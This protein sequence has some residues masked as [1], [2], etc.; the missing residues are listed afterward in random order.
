MTL[1]LPVIGFFKDLAAKRPAK[2]LFLRETLNLGE[3]RFLAI[4]ECDGQRLLIGGGT[5]GVNL[6]T[7][8]EAR[9]Q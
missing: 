1:A 5:H 4:V 6:V 2:S 3:K 8:L 7:K 9:E